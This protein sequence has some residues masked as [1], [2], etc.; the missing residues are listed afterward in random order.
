MKKY[1]D[2]LLL[3]A[4][5]SFI[6]ALKQKGSGVVFITLG[7]IFVIIHVVMGAYYKNKNS[8]P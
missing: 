8:T 2:W 6:I 4:L 7:Y 1:K 5:G 3:I